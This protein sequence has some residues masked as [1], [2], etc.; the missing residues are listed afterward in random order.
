MPVPEAVNQRWSMD[1]VSDQGAN[2]RRFRVRNV[3]D[4]LPCEYVLTV[5]DSSISRRR[6]ACEVERLS[7]RLPKIIV[8]DS[9]PEFRSKAMYFCAK[10]A[11]VKPRFIRP[12]KPTRNAFV[13]R[14][15]SKMRPHCLDLHGFEGIE[16]A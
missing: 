11:G 1:G 10:Q 2:G 15:G 4:D 14:F 13:A 12:G 3:V 7:S 9:G 8:C 6:V 16:D 5:V